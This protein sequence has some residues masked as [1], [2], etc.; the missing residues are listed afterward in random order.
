MSKQ[1]SITSLL[2]NKT[3]GKTTPRIPLLKELSTFCK[4]CQRREVFLHDL[5]AS[6]QYTKDQLCTLF[7]DP[8]TRYKGVAFKSWAAAV[9]VKLASNMVWDADKELA[10]KV[11]VTMAVGQAAMRGG[12]G[13]GGGGGRGG[14][15]RG[16]GGGGLHRQ[17]GWYVCCVCEIG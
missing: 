13:G 12:G 3:T 7:I 14:G 16:G 2:A 10:I 5:A 11:D 9:K 15:G 1:L 8:E 6:L 17:P 4:V